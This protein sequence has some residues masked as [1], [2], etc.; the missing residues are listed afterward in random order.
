MSHHSPSSSNASA[1]GLYGFSTPIGG[2]GGSPR[3]GPRPAADRQRARSKSTTTSSTTPV[4]TSSRSSRAGR[5]TPDGSFNMHFGYLNRNWVQEL[6]D[7]GRPEQQ[8]RTWRSRSR[9]ADVLLHAHAAQSVHGRR[10]E[11]LGQEGS[12]LDDRRQRED[13]EGLRLAAAGMGNRPRRRR[14][15]RRPDVARAARQ[16]AADDRRSIAASTIAAGQTLPLTVHRHRRRHSEAGGAEE[17]G[18]R[19]GNAAWPG[20]ATTTCRSTCR[21]C[22]P[23]RASGA[24]PAAASAQ[25]VD[26]S[27]PGWC[28]AVR[29]TPRSNRATSR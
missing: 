14:R 22:A 1:E 21:S 3:P 27:S 19:P 13:A 18:G 12:D 7:P 2:C 10:A 28:I 8:R 20:R 15:H 17:A 26:R 29:P 25:S 4:R 24:A 9:A 6:V 5:E 23:P 16:Q 11:G